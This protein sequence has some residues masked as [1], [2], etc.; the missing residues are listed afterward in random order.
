[1]K[2]SKFL[3]LTSAWLAT[4]SASALP[5]IVWHAFLQHEEVSFWI[6]VAQLVGFAVSFGLTT[7]SLEVRQVRGFLWALLAL[8]IGD[9]VVYGIQ[10]TGG[11]LVWAQSAQ[12]VDRFL[13]NALLS[14]IPSLLMVLT[15]IGSG[16]GRRELFLAKGDLRA[17]STMPFGL[18][19][20]RW[21]ILG[22]FLII[23]FTFPLMLQLV[24]TVRPDFAMAGRA[25][26]ALPLILIFAALNAASEEFR[27]RSV[28]IARIRTLLGPGQALLLTS[29]LF[30]LGHWFGH[31]SGPSGVL[32]A[33]IAGWF[34]GKSMIETRGFFWAWVI[35]AIQDV[36]IVAFVV[37]ASG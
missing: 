35:H 27:F 2:E 15:L 24:L 36:V 8:A 32:M 10:T 31:P 12:R 14:L 16:I 4:L 1:M 21:T 30:G 17:P 3:T 25:V 13:A 37:M 9:W 29:A 18:R 33:G 6:P 23:L 34:W 26:S 22:P 20:I 7:V 11:W 28:L 5:F 19:P